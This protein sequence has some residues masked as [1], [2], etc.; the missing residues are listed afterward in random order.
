MRGYKIVNNELERTLLANND[1]FQ[2][3]LNESKKSLQEEDG[4][5]SDYF[6]QYVDNLYNAMPLHLTS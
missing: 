5:K 2:D 4:M 6:W 1:K 3:I